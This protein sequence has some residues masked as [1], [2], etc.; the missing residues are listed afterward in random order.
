[1][2]KLGRVE[3]ESEDSDGSDESDGSTTTQ[4]SVYDEY[5]DEYSYD[6]SGSASCSDRILNDAISIA[7]SKLSPGSRKWYF[8]GFFLTRIFTPLPC[9]PHFFF[10][11]I[12]QALQLPS[13]YGLDTSTKKISGQQRMGAGSASQVR[14]G[15]WVKNDVFFKVSILVFETMQH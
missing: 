9:F 5:M 14:H 2:K 3:L 15:T 12:H 1:M 10:R 13:S 7:K 8:H 6:S 11:Q 4:T